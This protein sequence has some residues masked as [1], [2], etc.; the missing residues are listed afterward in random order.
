MAAHPASPAA[1]APSLSGGHLDSHGKPEA[2]IKLDLDRTV[3]VVHPHLFGSFAELL[4]NIIYGGLVDE[5][6][7]LSDEDGY[8]KDVMEAV[9]QMGVSLLR[10]PG[11][12]FSSGYNWKDGVGPKDQRPVRV[13]LAW[14]ALENN[15]FGTDEF[16]R[17]CERVGADPFICLNLGLG[18]VDEAR[19]W[20]EYTN[21]AR[22]TFWADERR[23]NGRD[24]PYGVK[25]WGLGNE[26]DGDWQIGHKNAQDYAKAALETAKVIRW[27]D[28]DVKLVA[29]GSSDFKGDW[30]G[31]N[32]TILRTLRDHIDYI[33]LHRYIG[34]RYDDLERF[35]GFSESL[36]HYIEVTAGLIRQV[37]AGQP[38]PRPIYVAFDEWNV[39][40]RAHLWTAGDTE[41]LKEVY[42]F[43]AA[44]AVG[45]FFNC[46]LRHADVVKMANLSQL[47]NLIAPIVT[48][49]KGIFLQPTYFPVAEY[50]RQRGHQSLDV[51]VQGP[52]Y[53]I[54]HGPPLQYL[55]VS[56][57][58]DEQASSACV[59]VLNRSKGADIRAR[60][61]VA[62]ATVS[63]RL[64]VWQMNH[65]DLKATHTFGDDH[66]LRPAIT[67]QTV[68]GGPAGFEFL[69]PAHSLTILRLALDRGAR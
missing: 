54:D 16:L 60:V 43:E 58:H 66:K 41:S 13:E 39:W 45:M 63:S 28:P 47:V 55:D 3:G 51:A 35:L 56:A 49:E 46:F 61:G 25:V 11:G 14:N 15:R 29:S 57:T 67:V 5:G 40:T 65:E 21:E 69:F 48:N 10:W 30:I 27:L 2:R 9:R 4:G 44:L 24:A 17:Y 42:N 12:N 33:G 8:R 53:R 19:Q 31:W 34:N 6:S 1:S 68:T 62:G 52:T 64:G 18:S 20:V 32:E 37:Q 36:E 7:P 22:R 50:S 26:L 59:N 38:N 23:R